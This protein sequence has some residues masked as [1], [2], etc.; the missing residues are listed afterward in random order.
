MTFKDNL[1]LFFKG[2]V[3]LC[4]KGR[5][6]LLFKGIIK[7]TF[8][9]IAKMPL[10]FVCVCVCDKMKRVFL[11]FLRMNPRASSEKRR[12]KGPSRGDPETP[13][14]PKWHSFGCPE[15]RRRN[16]AWGKLVK[17]K[18]CLKM[19][20]TF[21]GGEERGSFFC[22]FYSILVFFNCFFLFANNDS[23]RFD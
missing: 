11:P 4:F 17:R 7:L 15:P 3:K 20:F 16:W 19:P 8:K 14:M 5:A 13:S 10:F 22:L 23:L 18:S 2:S 12:R 6:K 1:K 21:F 9:Y